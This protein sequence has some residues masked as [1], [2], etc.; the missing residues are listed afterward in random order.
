MLDNDNRP[1]EFGPSGYMKYLG[2]ASLLGRIAG[3]ARLSSDDEEVLERAFGD[4][5][6]VLRERGSSLSFKKTHDGGYSLFD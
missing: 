4:V 5:N 3:K 1:R 2:L 6:D